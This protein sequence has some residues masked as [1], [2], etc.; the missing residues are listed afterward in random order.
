MYFLPE[1]IRVEFTRDAMSVA[2]DDGR[3]ISVPIAWYPRLLHATLDQLK[4]YE[5][6]PAG[7]HWDA[8]DEDISVDGI[9]KGFGDITRFRPEAA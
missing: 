8:L 6:S 5:L 4:A 2:L 9:L 7:I 3:I 1:P